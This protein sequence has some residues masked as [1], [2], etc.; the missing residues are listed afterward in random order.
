M[1]VSCLP[2][3]LL[4][5]SA[6]ARVVVSDAYVRPMMPGS[7][8]TAAYMVLDNQGGRVVRLV[9]VTSPRAQ[10]GTLRQG[11]EA[12]TR[13]EGR[14]RIVR[15]IIIPAGGSAWL[16]PGGLHISLQGITPP[17]KEGELLP[18]TL[19]FDDGEQL[20]LQLPVRNAPAP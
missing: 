2:L 5:V 13:D 14:M 16:Q 4:A 12:Q 17:L 1:R 7:D 8:T 11:Q 18:L 15:R 6:Q 9:L 10:E 3:L 19:N 20:E